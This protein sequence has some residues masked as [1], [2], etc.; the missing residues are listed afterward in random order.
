MIKELLNY[1]GE[2][3]MA[4]A[5]DAEANNLLEKVTKMWCLVFQDIETEQMYIF[6]NF[7]QFNY[8][9]VTDPYDNKQ[10]EIPKRTGTLAQGVEFMQKR[11]KKLICHNVFGYDHFLIK[12]FFPKYRMKLSRYVDTLTHSKIQWYDRPTPKGCKGAHGLA[13][14][15]ARQGFHKPDVSDWTIMDAFKLH[16]CIEDV[17]IQTGTYKLLQAE[18]EKMESVIGASIDESINTENK[19]AFEATIQELDGAPVDVPHMR[20]CVKEL[21]EFCEELRS[22]IEPQLP[23]T[24][25]VKS[26]RATAHT[27]ATLVGAKRIPPVRY[28]WKEIKGIQ[29]KFEVKSFYRPVVKW[30]TKDRLVMYSAV[31]VDEDIDT[32]FKFNKLKEARNYVKENYPD[33]KKGWKYPKYESERELYNNHTCKHFNLKPEDSDLKTFVGKDGKEYTLNKG[34]VAGMHTKVEFLKSTMSQ[35]AVVKDFLLSLGWQPT[36]WNIK[37]DSKGKPERDE[38]GKLIK[39]S[40]KLTEDSFESLPEGVGRDIANF[41]TYSHRR[42][43]IANPTDNTKGLLNRVRPDGRVSCGINN[44][45]TSTGR[46]SH[47]NWVN[48]AGVGALY[49]DK[50]RQIIRVQSD[51]RRL[52]GADMKSAQLS[53]A[54]YYANNYDYYIAVADGQEVIKDDKGNEIYVGESGHCVNARAFGLVSEAEYQEAL[55]TQNPDLLHSIMLRRGKSKGGTFATLFGASGNKVA[56]TLGIDPKIGEERRIR[57]LEEIGLDEPIARLE[58]QMKTYK[59]GK[60]GYIE[61]PFDYWAYCQQPHKLFNYL[62]QGTEAVCQKIA[63]LHFKKWLNKEVK[64]GNIDAKKV[65]DYHDEFLCESHEDCAE[66]VGKAMTDSYKFASDACFEWHQTKS[67]HFKDLTFPFNLDG[68]FKVG[69]DYLSVH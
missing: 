37:K 17:R 16:R 39:T 6:H 4:L 13:A 27:V 35:H 8:A 44:F 47:S 41:N 1:Q 57:F 7:P 61:L 38:R 63:V 22:H 11:G 19:Y 52:V 28:Q 5:F 23:D 29:K 40:P 15:G 49:G 67:K 59:R 3:D 60:G 56:S 55:R 20:S 53:I 25:K 64:A 9:I 12:K 69:M 42:K 31:N 34:I 24:L 2:P 45:G 36:E 46:S 50:I 62:D 66:E 65:L 51:D 33:I 32:G 26:T 30:T 14:W 54:A 10:Y 18:K 21:D 58:Q 68:G 48:A 43:F